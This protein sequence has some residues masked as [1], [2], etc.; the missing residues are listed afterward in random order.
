M[1]A[2]EIRNMTKEEMLRTLAELQDEHFKLRMRRASEELP[3]PIRLRMLRRD[4]ARIKTIL[5]E[6]ELKEKKDKNSNKKD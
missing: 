5:R 4:I 6:M 3:N 2:T 1:K